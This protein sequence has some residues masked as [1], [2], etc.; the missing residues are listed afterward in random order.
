M[1]KIVAPPKSYQPLIDSIIQLDEVSFGQMMRDMSSTITVDDAGNLQFFLD[2]SLPNFDHADS[3]FS[4]LAVLWTKSYVT[5]DDFSASFVAQCQKGFDDLVSVDEDNAPLLT[6][7]IRVILMSLLPIAYKIK[8]TR[9]SQEA[10]N[11]YLTSSVYS[12]VRFVFD[13]EGRVL[14]AHHY[15]L[16]RLRFTVNSPGNGIKHLEI[17]LDSDA[18]VELKQALSRAELKESGLRQLVARS[19][20]DLES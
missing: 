13:N 11:L 10:D 19:L 2:A 6:E 3:L 17:T 5:V 7:R 20:A 14:P 16:H 1:A 12:D 9:D 15:I 18:L 4:A 8:G